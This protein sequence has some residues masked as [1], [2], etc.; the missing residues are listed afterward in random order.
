MSNEIDSDEKQ[1]VIVDEHVGCARKPYN[2]NYLLGS[3]DISQIERL[4][5]I[6]KG[7]GLKQR[8]FT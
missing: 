3:S 6:N 1:R 5:K 2:S 4:L 7:E 8:F